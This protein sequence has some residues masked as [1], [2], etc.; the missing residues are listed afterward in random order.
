VKAQIS[1]AIKA[2]LVRGA[3]YL[4]LLVA[5][6]VIPFALAQRNATTSAIDTAKTS[7]AVGVSSTSR[8]SEAHSLPTPVVASTVFLVWD[9]YDSAG[10]AATLSATFT[11]A[12][13]MN[14][15]LADDFEVPA[16]YGWVVRWIDVD[17]AYFNGPGPANS[18]TVS[19]Y[20]DNDGFPGNQVYATLAPQWEQNG[21]TFRVYVC[22]APFECFDL[23]PG[24]YWVEIQANMTAKCCG[25]W[26]WTDRT[27]TRL[28]PAVWRNPS[29]FFGACTSW[30]RRAATCGLDPLAPDQVYRIYASVIVV[31]TPTPTSTVT[32]TP[33]VTTQ[34][35]SVTSPLCGFTVFTP[36]TTFDINVLCGVNP[37]TVQASDLTVNG[38]PA[39]TFTLINGNT[40]I[41]FQYINSPAV[42]GQN[43]MHIAAGAFNCC[44]APVPE[45]TCTFT[46]QTPTVTPTLP[47]PSPTATA[48]P[49]AT[50][51]LT[52]RPSPTPRVAPM[53]R[54]HPTPPPR[55]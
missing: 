9:Q 12:P 54:V 28:N 29:G 10:T 38:I 7:L 36:P 31:P 6:C 55:P 41:R 48:T 24:R 3:F 35:C 34:F 16:G 40:T 51:T 50:P 25:E 49:T 45:F 11:D 30:S 27:V 5:L 52:P 43:T 53:P 47:P 42:P 2:R 44:N 18:F 20:A 8:A 26:G 17:G 13:A 19:F 37:A 22:F 33:T 46:Y 39:D 15:D 23:Y 32:P 21:S 4:L 14:S 1:P